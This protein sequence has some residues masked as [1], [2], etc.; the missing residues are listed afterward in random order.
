MVL[1]NKDPAHWTKADCYAP[2]VSQPIVRL[3]A[4]L[5]VRNRTTLK[6]GDCKN[7]FCH[8]ALPDDEI[9]IVRPPSH[10]PFSR[11]RTYWRLK[12]TLYGLRRSPRH[13]FRALAEALN[14]VGLKSIPNED[15]LFVGNPIEGKPP[16]YLAMYV[17]DLVYFLADPEVEA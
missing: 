4:A 5:A 6:Q 2:T 7:A 12:K 16:L 15:C 17:D 3:M 8:P 10:C 13:W 1:G 9:I 14:K 11:P